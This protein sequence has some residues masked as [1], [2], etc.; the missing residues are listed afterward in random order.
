MKLEAI[1]K[2]G[3]GFRPKYKNEVK[4]VKQWSGHPGGITHFWTLGLF[5]HYLTTWRDDAVIRNVYRRGWN[6]IL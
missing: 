5:E 4:T 1:G 2:I 6:Q 3:S